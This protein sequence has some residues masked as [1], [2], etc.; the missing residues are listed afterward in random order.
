M[1]FSKQLKNLDKDDLLEYVGLQTRKGAV[2]FL[3]PTLAAFGVGVLVGAGVGLLL[4]PKSGAALRDDLRQ[5][6][7]GGE[8]L[9]GTF[10]SAV[11]SP[12]SPQKTI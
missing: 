1:N 4:A 10:P 11:S 12:N 3:V 9:G 6:I 2:D 5:R 7:Q 8:Q